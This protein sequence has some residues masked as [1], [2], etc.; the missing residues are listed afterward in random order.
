[1]SDEPQARIPVRGPAALIA[2]VPH[3]LGFHP[4][5]SLVAVALSGPHGRVRTVFRYD[6]PDPPDH[7]M[8]ESIAAHFTAIMDREHLATA[9]LI[10]YGTGALVTPVTDVARHLLPRNGIRLLDILR[11]DEGR[12][13]SYLCTD[14]D[15]CPPG[16][17]P[18][19]PAHP[20]ACALLATAGLAAAPSRADVAARIAAV[21]GPQAAAMTRATRQAEDETARRESRGGAAAA[22]AAG[23]AAVRDAITCYRSGA[24]ITDPLVLARVTVALTSLRVRD[25]AWARMTP[26]HKD[27]HLRLWT[28]VTRHARPGYAAAPAS[29]LA[30]TAWQD[31]DGALGCISQAIQAGLPPSKAVLPMT[32][33]QVAASYDRQ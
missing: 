20:A 29:L 2:V 12:Y 26:D 28:D 17:H 33:E 30:F 3:L 15:C 9:T 31:G 21:T 13:W 14:P 10:G 22:D 27:A 32:P 4:S 8:A 11:V 24:T 19:D 25:D 18:V 6:L 23:L 1:M 5:N 7:A 16:G